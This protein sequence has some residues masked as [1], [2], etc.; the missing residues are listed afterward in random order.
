MIERPRPLAICVFRNQ[1]QILV[2]QGADPQDGRTFLRPL[3][4]GIEFGETSAEAVVREVREE[5]GVEVRNVQLLGVLENLFTYNGARGHEIVFVY[6][7]AFLTPDYYQA[8][9]LPAREGEVAFPAVWVRLSELGVGSP[10]L[11][12]DGLLDLLRARAT[13]PPND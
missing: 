4:G 8:S 10:P 11:Y 9:E 2:S 5:L 7:A 3:G 12:P 6:D 13:D 1:G